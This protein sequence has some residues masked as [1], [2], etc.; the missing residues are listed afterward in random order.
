MERPYEIK[1]TH[2]A[3][4]AL[5]YVRQSSE[6]QVRDNRGSAEYQRG[7]ARLAEAWGWARRQVEDLERR[8]MAVDPEN[9]LV[10]AGVEAQL[11]HAKRELLARE[12]AAQR[13]PSRCERPVAADLCELE[14]LANDVKR[15]FEAPTTTN[16]DRKEILRASSITSPSR[17]GRASGSTRGSAGLMIIRKPSS[18]SA[19][20]DMAGHR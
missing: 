8:Y 13:A 4:K 14:H 6:A 17:A 20:V 15:L 2:L 11:E 1:A 19:G 12:A 10:A 5:V 18:A 7:L 16:R 9:R 3:R